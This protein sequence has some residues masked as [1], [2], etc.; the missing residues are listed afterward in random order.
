[1]SGE[2]LG[3]PRDAIAMAFGVLPGL[4]S[5]QGQGPLVRERLPP[6]MFVLSLRTG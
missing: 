4:F 2:T 1:M 5:A 3:A 6:K